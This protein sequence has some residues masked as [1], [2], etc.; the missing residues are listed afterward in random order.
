MA[1]IITLRRARKTK[2]KAAATHQA[3]ANRIKFGRTR[4]QKAADVAED[5]RLIRR[6]DGHKRTPEETPG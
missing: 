1:E 4:A 2:A 6:L 5:E 3:A